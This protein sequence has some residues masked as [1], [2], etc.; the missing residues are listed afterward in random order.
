MFLLTSI[1]LFA[2]QLLIDIAAGQCYANETA[3]LQCYTAPENIP[4]QVNLTDIAFVAAYL[5]SYGKQLKAGRFLTMLTTDG[6]NCPEWSLYSHG[7]ALVTA[8]HINSVVNS[9][10]L[11][12]DIA[13]TIDGGVS[14]RVDQQS[15]AL[16]G[17]GSDG[18]AQGVAYNATD[19][20]YNTT[21]Y[22]ASGYIP[23]GILIKVVSS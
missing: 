6:S 13:D 17:C 3:A 5:R 1:K 19:P 8:K 2:I 23:S 10:V 22:L 12:A 9:S 18:G 7:S 20:S 15:T 14:A 21:T 4:Q 16:I 11:F